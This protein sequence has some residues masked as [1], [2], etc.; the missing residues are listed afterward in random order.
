MTTCTVSWSNRKRVKYA[1]RLISLRYTV[2]S[3]VVPSSP[4]LSAA[5]FFLRQGSTLTI[6][7]T[8]SVAFSTHGLP[9]MHIFTCNF[10]HT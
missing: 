9:I 2:V 1:G 5:E 10:Q 7:I 4:P 8:D 6:N 3:N